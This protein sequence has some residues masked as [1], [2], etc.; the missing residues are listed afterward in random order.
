MPCFTVIY[1]KLYVDDGHIARNGHSI[2]QSIAEL[3]CCQECCRLMLSKCKTSRYT[4][5]YTVFETG[6]SER[7]VK[8][9]KSSQTRVRVA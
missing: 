7:L 4:Y 1:G 5:M 2:P 8:P 9:A 6:G 3:E